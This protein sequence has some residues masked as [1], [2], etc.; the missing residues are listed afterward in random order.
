MARKDPYAVQ[1]R[2]D[3]ERAVAQIADRHGL[4]RAQ[5]TE[6][7]GSRATDAGISLHAAA[8]AALS[9]GP[10]DERA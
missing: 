3:V 2:R 8:L 1:D 7:L 5:G 4:T 10:R 9:S 6:T